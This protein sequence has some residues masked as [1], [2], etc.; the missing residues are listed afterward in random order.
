M[1][2][3]AG[4]ACVDGVFLEESLAQKSGI[5]VGGTVRIFW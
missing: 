2:I 1:A 5:S 3:I 4:L